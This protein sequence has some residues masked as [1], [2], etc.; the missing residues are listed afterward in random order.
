MVECSLDHEAFYKRLEH[1]ADGFEVVV[2]HFGR[3]IV[4]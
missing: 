3:S 2:E 4:S 1:S